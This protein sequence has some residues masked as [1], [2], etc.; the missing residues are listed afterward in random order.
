MA[1]DYV[2]SMMEQEDEERR[3][4]NIMRDAAILIIKGYDINSAKAHA[5][6]L[7]NAQYEAIR[8]NEVIYEGEEEENIIGF[9]D[10][11]IDSPSAKGLNNS[12]IDA[13]YYE[14]CEEEGIS[15]E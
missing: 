15:S 9:L 7:D 1:S 2:T 8:N 14:L 10:S 13:K 12:E 3:E 6:E 11:S 4:R 5:R